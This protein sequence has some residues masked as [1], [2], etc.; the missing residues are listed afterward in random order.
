MKLPW[1]YTL[2]LCCLAACAAVESQPPSDP[3]GD[4]GGSGGMG[5]GATVTT[6]TGGSAS[7]Q[8]E[9]GPHNDLI[10]TVSDD[11]EIWSFD[12]SDNSFSFVRNLLCTGAEQPFSMAVDHRG[13]AWVLSASTNLI[14]TLDL[15]ASDGCDVSPYTP[16]QTNFDLF[17]MA[18]SRSDN[19]SCAPLYVHSFSGQGTFSEGPAAGS[20]A[21]IDPVSGVLTNLSTID[22]DGGELAGSG[23]GRLFAFA[24]VSPA[25]LIEYDKSSGQ[26]LSTLPLNGV[27]KT[28]ASAFAFFAGDIYFFTEALPTDCMPCL[29]QNCNT[30][31]QACLMDPVCNDH[32]NCAIESSNISD[33]CGG[34]MPQPLQNCIAGPCLTDCFVPPQVRVSQVTRLDL[35]N[36]DGGGL[37][38][39]VQEGPIRVVGAADSVCV[40]PTPR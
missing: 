9:P 6:G 4:V 8:C 26:T 10:Y 3:T 22:Y 15:N 11:E 32:L 12:P 7:C 14:F 28:N 33:D 20:L 2:G 18:F 5:G 17:G 16:Y 1:S 13:Q 21:V 39:V 25:K 23:D 19:D 30:E 34:A 35:D 29:T 31:L 40:P 27:S 36:N 38:I 24:G 37:Q